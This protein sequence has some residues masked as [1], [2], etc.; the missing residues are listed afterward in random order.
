MVKSFITQSPKDIENIQ[1]HFSNQQL[2]DV[3]NLIHK[4]KPSITFMGIHSLKDLVVDMEENAKHK[5]IEL[6]EEQLE[7]FEN[8][9]QIAIKELKEEFEF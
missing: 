1:F 3:A 2:D 4:I 8:T 7:R 6:L 5:N 9:C